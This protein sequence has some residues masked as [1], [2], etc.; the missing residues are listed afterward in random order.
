MLAVLVYLWTAALARYPSQKP[1]RKVALPRNY[2][3][4][5]VAQILGVSK[6]LV[7]RLNGTGE[8]PFF[9]VGRLRRIRQADLESYIEASMVDGG[10][11]AA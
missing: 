2:S 9:K 7:Y 4:D 8:L 5:E 10:G 1:K 3:I 11:D 6:P